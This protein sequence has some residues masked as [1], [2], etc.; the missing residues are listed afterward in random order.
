VRAPA[1]EGKAMGM[2]PGPC[3][4]CGGPRGPGSCGLG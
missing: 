3:G 2:P 4:S 1:R